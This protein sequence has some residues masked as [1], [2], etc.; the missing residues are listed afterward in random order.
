MPGMIAVA[1]EAGMAN[2]MTAIRVNASRRIDFLVILSLPF[3]KENNC[4]VKYTNSIALFGDESM[5]SAQM[6]R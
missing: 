4:I 6:K 5:Q 1:A 3:L 2:N